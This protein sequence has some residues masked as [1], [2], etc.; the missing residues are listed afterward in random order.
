MTDEEAADALNL[1]L[2]TLQREWHRARLWL[3]QRLAGENEHQS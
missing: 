1:K 3:Y 2:H